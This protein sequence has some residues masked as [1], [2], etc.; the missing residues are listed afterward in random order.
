L[1]ILILFVILTIFHSSSNGCSVSCDLPVV[2]DDNLYIGVGVVVGYSGNYYQKDIEGGYGLLKVA[3]SKLYN[4]N[5]D[6]DTINVSIFGLGSLCETIGNSVEY[7]QESYSL[8]QSISFIGNKSML[9]ADSIIHITIGPCGYIF[10]G[11]MQDRIG[12]DYES[13]RKSP[14]LDERMDNNLDL[15]ED[16][17]LSKNESWGGRELVKITDVSQKLIKYL[18]VPEIFQIYLDI[19]AINQAESKE[20]R[21]Y[22][23]KRLIWSR[24]IRDEKFISKQ[25][26]T[27]KQKTDL[28]KEQTFIN[29]K[30]KIY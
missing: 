1:K 30:W 17:L 27:K 11:D 24:Y 10:L 5:T 21:Y 13:L 4:P 19:V 3:I 20:L 14:S 16:E 29:E 2:L 26:I 23:L 22:I 12:Y 9:F 8:N 15:M 25:K 18:I 7:L 6:V 28:L